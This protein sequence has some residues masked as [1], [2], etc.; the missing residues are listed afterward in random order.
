[1]ARA[2]PPPPVMPA[3]HKFQFPPSIPRA[4]LSYLPAGV[5]RVFFSCFDVQIGDKITFVS[6]TFG[7]QIWSAKGV[8]M[9]RVQSAIKVGR[10]LG[11]PLF[12]RQTFVELVWDLLSVAEGSRVRRACEGGGCQQ[13]KVGVGFRKSGKCFVV[14]GTEKCCVLLYTSVLQSGCMARVSFIDLLSVVTKGNE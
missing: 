3:C 11:K 12:M 2:A 4:P 14:Q 8:G 5:G 7:D 13:S 1:M 9:S 10:L 6:A